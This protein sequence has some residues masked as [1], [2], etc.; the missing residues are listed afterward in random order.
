MKEKPTSIFDL[1]PAKKLQLVE[2]LWDDLASNPESVPIQDW[3]K[4]EL[5]RRKAN[6]L[7]NPASGLPWE[8][9]NP[10]HLVETIPKT[11]CQPH[12]DARRNLPSRQITKRSQ[13]GGAQ[14]R[15]FHSGG[16]CSVTPPFSTSLSAH[17]RCAQDFS[18]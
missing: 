10:S 5:D 9:L 16:V 14:S 1:T 12:R 8:Q 2:D 6:L 15:Q 17:S 7:K 4:S 11:L 13:S 3:Q 18:T